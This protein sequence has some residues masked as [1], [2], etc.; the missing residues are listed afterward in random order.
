VKK[1]I[2][3]ALLIIAA[4][5]MLVAVAALPRHGALDTPVQTHLSAHYLEFGVEEA[6]AE[7]IVTDVILN[8]RGFDTEIEVTVIFTALA[9]VLALMLGASNGGKASAAGPVGQAGTTGQQSSGSDASM[10]VLFVVRL[11]AP[12]TAMFAIYVILNGHLT[13]GGG[14]QGGAILGALFITLTVMLGEARVAGAFPETSRRWL[15]IAAPLTFALAGVAGVLLTGWYLG[16][17]TEPALS[18]VR[19]LMLITIEIGIGVGGAAII[20]TLFTVMEAE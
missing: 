1:A 15:Q 2:V 19:T 16:Y 10:V 20:A 11:L 13:P 14:F 5:P 8:Y 12:F 6:G 7:N 3:T 17:P 9:A 18:A 4:I